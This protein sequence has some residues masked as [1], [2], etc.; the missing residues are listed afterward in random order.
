[1]KLYTSEK[2]EDLR[3]YKLDNVLSYPEIDLS[4]WEQI[5][6]INEHY[7]D[8]INVKTF[9]PYILNALNVIILKH[10]L[11]EKDIEVYSVYDGELFNL[12]CHDGDK[13]MLVD[14]RE[15]S[16]PI[17]YIYEEYIELKEKKMGDMG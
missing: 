8:D 16:D 12:I 17:S 6:W 11:T 5:E 4:P 13:Q 7:N 15:L 14:T 10:N 1:M 9:S 3:N 2:S